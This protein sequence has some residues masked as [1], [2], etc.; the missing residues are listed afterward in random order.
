MEDA[1]IEFLDRLHESRNKNGDDVLNYLALTKTLFSD[2]T[3]HFSFRHFLDTVVSAL[4]ET[5]NLDETLGGVFDEFRDSCTDSLTA[6][7]LGAAAYWNNF[8][9]VTM[10]LNWDEASINRTVSRP[11]PYPECDCVVSVMT[12]CQLPR[13]GDRQAGPS[14]ETVAYLLGMGAKAA[15]VEDGLLG[16]L[17]CLLRQ[18]YVEPKTFLPKVQSVVECITGFADGVCETGTLLET[19]VLQGHMDCLEQRLQAFELLLD[20]RAKATWGSPLAALIYMSGPAGLVEKVLER[21]ADVN[22]YCSG[23]FPMGHNVEGRPD[24]LDNINSLNPLQAAALRCHEGLVDLL[25]DNRADVNCPARGSGGMTPLQSVCFPKYLVPRR[26]IKSLE[27]QKKKGRIAKLLL[28]RGANVNAAPAW[29]FG[30]TALQAAAYG[31][32]MEL[33]N[34]L[35]SR[36]ANVNAPACK[37]GGGTA[38]AMAARERDVKMV[39]YLLAEGAEIPAAIPK[40]SSSPVAYDDNKIVMDLLRIQAPELVATYATRAPHSRDYREYE[41]EWAKDPTYVRKG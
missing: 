30:L 22:A 35:V 9:A 12:Y 15:G 39:R 41:A 37:Y 19:C 10:L 17:D 23:V 33:A 40:V 5:T 32:D 4:D 6:R 29:N 24:P 20:R 16:L 31:G 25:L 36:G 26:S 2:H 13:F 28:D 14:D 11:H 8:E 38:L 34:F 3:S 27:T 7:A 21:T 18:R 1:L